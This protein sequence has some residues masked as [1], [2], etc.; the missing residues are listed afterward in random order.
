MA[1]AAQEAADCLA[2]GDGEYFRRFDANH[3]PSIGQGD[4]VYYVEDGYVRG[5]C[6]V[7]RVESRTL[8]CR[9]DTTGRAWA[10]GI[11]VFM[12][13]DSWQW[14]KPIPMRG[15]MGWRAAF[16]YLHRPHA[17]EEQWRGTALVEIVGDWKA[18][19]P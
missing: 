11:Y 6:R 12:R 3:Y 18:P 9:C 15:F 4:R 7:D 19:R 17:L 13:A 14:I 10:P 1:N 2:A 8:G 5:F 16:R